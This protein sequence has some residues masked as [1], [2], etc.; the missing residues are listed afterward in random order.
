MKA[1]VKASKLLKEYELRA[2]P[3]VITVNEFNE[4]LPQKCPL[5]TTQ[6]KRSFQSLLI[7]TEERSTL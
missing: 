1:I 6:A 7:L 2:P 3:I 4:S 5:P